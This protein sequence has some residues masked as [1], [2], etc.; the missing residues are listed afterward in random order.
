[1]DTCVGVSVSGAHGRPIV[2]SREEGVFGARTT[3]LVVAPGDLDDADALVREG[4][5]ERG[6]HV[7]T[8]AHANAN[9]NANA[10]AEAKRQIPCPQSE[11]G[12]R[13][14]PRSP[15]EHPGHLSTTC[16]LCVFPFAE[17]EIV[18]PQCAPLP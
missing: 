4:R 17:T 9:A 12:A 2:P 13:G 1:M 8:N 15:E 14:S 5:E 6:R 11:E 3:S 16:A 7:C 18:L 10:N